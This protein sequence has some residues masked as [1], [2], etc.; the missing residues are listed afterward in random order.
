[1][2]SI[3]KL[4]LCEGSLK[5]TPHSEYTMIS[6]INVLTASFSTFSQV[7]FNLPIAMFKTL[8]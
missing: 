8:F 2:E 6:L 7:N 5:S 1:M 4:Y 3:L